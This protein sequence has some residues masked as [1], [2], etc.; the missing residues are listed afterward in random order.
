MGAAMVSDRVETGRSDRGDSRDAAGLSVTLR[1]DAP[2]PLELAFDCAPGE[3]VA[4]FGPS[5]SGKSTTLRAIAGLHHPQYGLIRCR[6][7]TWLDTAA[8]IDCAP[9][10]RAVGLVFQEYALFPHRDALGN[11]TAALGHV[12]RV[13]RRARA[14]ELLALVQLDGLALRYPSQLS[15]GQRQRLALARALARD[16]A[17]LLLD[18]PFAA[19]DRALRAT[20]HAELEIVRRTVHLPIVL[21][22]HDFDEVARLADRLVLIERGRMVATGP[23]AELAASADVEA[24]AAYHEPGSIFDATVEAHDTTRRLTRLAFAGGA[25]RAPLMSAEPGVRLRLRI[26]A[27]EVALAL[28]E[29]EGIS[30]HNVLRATVVSVVSTADPALVLVKLRIGGAV[31]LAQVT[32]DA[33]ERLGLEPGLAVHALI[34]SVSVLRPG[35]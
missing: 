19:V 18:E 8:R 6:G 27:Q 1:Q 11:V 20:L 30:V 4:L 22:T 29:P 24:L 7:E 32:Y 23:V 9:H 16:P 13:L 25:L 28:S 17:V 12:P 34:K 35:E 26:A 10:R 31:L 2:I 21:V 15:G 33:V 5:G 14:R 3:M